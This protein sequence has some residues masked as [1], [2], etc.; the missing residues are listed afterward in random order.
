MS[1]KHENKYKKLLAHLDI[2]PHEFLMVGNSVKSDVLPV[3]NIGSQAIHIP[4]EV[5]WAHENQH[6]IPM[7]NSFINVSVISDI[8][9][10]L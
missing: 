7:D 2:Q 1:E 3:I 10:L 8:L 5:T 4:F 9:N 6:E